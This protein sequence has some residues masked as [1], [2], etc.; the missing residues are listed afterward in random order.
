LTDR[1]IGGGKRRG[2]GGGLEG[3]EW[4]G[5]GGKGWLEGQDLN[6]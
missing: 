4:L 5:E 3:A 6:E 2:E 1:W